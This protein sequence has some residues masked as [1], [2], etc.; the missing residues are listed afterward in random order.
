[1]SPLS[2]VRTKYRMCLPSLSYSQADGLA[3]VR[4]NGDTP[5]LTPTAMRPPASLYGMPAVPIQRLP[6]RTAH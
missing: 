4:D 3:R 1:M 2:L 6:Q 5:K